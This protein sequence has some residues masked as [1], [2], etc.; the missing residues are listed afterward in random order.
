MNVQFQELKTKKQMKKLS[1][2]MLV[3]LKILE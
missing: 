2:F 1:V 3:T